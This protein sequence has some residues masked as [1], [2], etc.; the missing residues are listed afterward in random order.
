MKTLELIQGSAE[1]HAHR[2]SHFNASDAPAVMGCS[3]YKTRAQLLKEMATG[4][5]AEVDSG[6]QRLF[7]AG[8]RFE[9]LAR[10]LAEK[11]ID[12]ELFAVVGVEGEL[13]AS[14]DG[15]TLMEDTAFEHKT[16][17]DSLRYTP[18][19]EG[20]GDHLPLHYRVQ[21]EH[22]IMVSGCA[23]VL[24]MASKWNGDQLVEER[25]CWYTSDG[26]LRGEIGR[27][28]AQFKEDL[29]AYVPEVT[30]TKVTA[31]AVESLPA[32]SV[33]M[34]GAIAVVSNLDLFGAKLKAFVAAIDK[35]PST[36]QAFANCEAAVSTLKK[37][38][39]ALDQ[40][41]AAAL[42]QIDPV[43]TMRRTVADYKELART[44]R[45]MLD[46]LV[47][48]RKEAIREE[49][50]AG[51]IASL[52]KHIDG[53]NTRIGRP[54]MPAIPADF[55]G[56]IKGKKTVES[57]RNAVDTELA[58][59]KIAANEVADRIQLNLAKLNERADMAFL[60]PDVAQIVLKQ[61]DDLQAL[62]TSRITAHEA[63]EAA[64]L[65]AERARIRA[66]EEAKAQREAAQKV[67]AEQAAARAISQAAAPAPV[68]APAPAPVATQVA[69]VV[70]APAPVA[71]DT[72][73]RINLGQINERIAPLSIT[74]AGL[75]TLGF[76]HVAT[77]R[78]SKLYRAND[79]G[80]MVAA[81]ANH[82]Q[83]LAVP[84]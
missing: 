81:M 19:D 9:A 58:R 29:A 73:E 4:L 71:A 54:C 63:K 79:F 25:H 78:A 5:T 43:E 66:E 62:V 47:K 14:F 76:E 8:H 1:W 23:R 31:E 42:A 26:K 65:E 55:G 56:V 46:K 68:T 61:A 64:R 52:R 75:S 28:W 3:P 33:R 67:A 82:L 53:L 48:A 12:E 50:V 16:L 35:N 13:S 21:M 27:A 18:W 36:D 20:N 72:G 59:A 49:I 57:L 24:F 74:A 30:A 6:T 32:V 38:E 84:A 70:A 77:E 45:L 80:R 11:I 39:D 37:A 60:F 40:A 41:E 83:N 34:D 17:N 51:G 2:A 15:L 44:T 7:D 10:P 69:P 22:Q